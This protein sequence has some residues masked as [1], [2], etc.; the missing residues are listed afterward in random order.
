MGIVHSSTGGLKPASKFLKSEVA[1]TCSIGN[2]L[3]GTS[4]INWSAFTTDYDLIR[5]SIQRVIPGF[6]EYNRRVREEGGFYL[7]NGPRGWPN[8][9]NTFW[10][11]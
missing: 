9:E 3:F 11:C 2:A 10:F 1:I 4:P 8:M 6:D 7:P 5:D